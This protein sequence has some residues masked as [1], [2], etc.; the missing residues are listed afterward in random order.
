MGMVLPV[1][2]VSERQDGSLLVLDAGDRLQYLMEFLE[3]RCPLDEKRLSEY[4]ELH[5]NTGI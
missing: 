3:G 2:Y 1:I 4:A 5:E